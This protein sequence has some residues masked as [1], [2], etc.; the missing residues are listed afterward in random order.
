MQNFRFNV[1]F[2]RK[3]NNF[4]P[5]YQQPSNGFCNKCQKT[6]PQIACAE[7]CEHARTYLIS[8]VCIV[9]MLGLKICAIYNVQ[10]WNSALKIIK[11][12]EQESQNYVRQI[13]M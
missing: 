9:C 6:E 2:R 4:K 8:D 7:Q 1:V 11:H 3:D 13:E 10:I 12:A 5:E